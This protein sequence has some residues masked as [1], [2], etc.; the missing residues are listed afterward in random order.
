MDVPEE[1][2]RRLCKEDVG[3]IV[4]LNN[5]LASWSLRSDMVGRSAG[6]MALV[7]GSA[8]RGE[9]PGTYCLPY[10]YCWYVFIVLTCSYLYVSITFC[11]WLLV[12]TKQT[13]GC[14]H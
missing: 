5:F 3:W 14:E 7:Y 1:G 10:C 11:N 6:K 8:V 13:A 4:D 12:R 2:G 9:V